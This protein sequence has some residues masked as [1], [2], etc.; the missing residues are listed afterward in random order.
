[1]YVVTRISVTVSQG[2]VKCEKREKIPGALL[3][4]CLYFSGKSS[5]MKLVS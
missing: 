5:S 1:M 3:T 4:N 2:T